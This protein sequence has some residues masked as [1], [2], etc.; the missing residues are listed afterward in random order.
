MFATLDLASAD[1]TYFFLFS[2]VVIILIIT[3]HIII[4]INIINTIHMIII[5]NMIII[6]II[7]IAGSYSKS[8]SLH[9]PK[10]G[11]QSSRFSVL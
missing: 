8:L 5:I 10:R 9:Q 1:D 4:T 6:L 11:R 2:I 7:N 3:I